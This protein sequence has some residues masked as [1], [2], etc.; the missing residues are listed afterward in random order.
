MIYKITAT[1]FIA[2]GLFGTVTAQRRATGLPRVGLIKDYPA[3]GMTVGCGNLY[4]ELP[5]TGINSGDKY[6]FLSRGDG[7]NGWIN[8]N[9]RDVSLRL[10]RTDT[11]YS[12]TE[13]FVVRHLYRYSGV[14]IIVTVRRDGQ[15]D[16]DGRMKMSITLRRGKVIKSFE[17]VG[18]SDC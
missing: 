2:A 14:S 16:A 6:V 17:A 15:P 18:T 13:S 12:S 9:G 4:V 1:L 8:L 10:L 3:T 5:D 11:M 7:T